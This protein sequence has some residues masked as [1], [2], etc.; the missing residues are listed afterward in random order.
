M[1]KLKLIK[2]AAVAIFIAAA[3][4]ATRARAEITVRGEGGNL[5]LIA[6]GATLRCA[7]IS[8]AVNGKPPVILT[9]AN[10]GVDLEVG[11]IAV[12]ASE[13]RL[14]SV[15]LKVTAPATQHAR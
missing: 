13:L 10:G 5:V 1:S 7:S 3:A 14:P 4:S 6:D 9:A 2:A 11:G 8:V 15:P 12:R